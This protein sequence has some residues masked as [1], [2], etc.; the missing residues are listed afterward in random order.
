MA[1]TLNSKVQTLL[2]C[3][4]ES[5][6]LPFDVGLKNVRITE[7]SLLAVDRVD[8]ENSHGNMRVINKL[9]LCFKP[10]SRISSAAIHMT[11]L[12]NTSLQYQETFN[13]NTV[14]LIE[15][16]IERL[17]KPVCLLAH[18]GQGFGFPLLKAEFE[19]TS[20][21]FSTP[22][23]C[24]DTLQAFKN[25][26]SK[27]DIPQSSSHN[28]TYVSDI[29][30]NDVDEI[31]SQDLHIFEEIKLPSCSNISEH[32]NNNNSKNLNGY[33]K[34]NGTNSVVLETISPYVNETTPRK[35]AKKE[36]TP[37]LNKYVHVKKNSTSRKQLFPTDATTPT[38]NASTEA[39]DSSK[40]NSNKISFKLSNLYEHFFH[41]SQ[42]YSHLAEADSISLLKIAREVNN[43]FLIWIDTH[44][45]PFETIKPLW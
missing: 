29:S 18:Y 12:C 13:Q 6:G 1:S 9:T 30:E 34:N 10:A 11:G 4:I 32:N 19:N 17:N 42:P 23:L 38:Q 25:I 31:L 41:S 43:E 40:K 7:L 22:L 27:Q 35:I 21:T 28:Y 5:T 37:T 8:F 39:K 3:D 26:L 24:A 33:S 20:A 44:N 2:F 36:I 14:K 45:I 16:F 15:L